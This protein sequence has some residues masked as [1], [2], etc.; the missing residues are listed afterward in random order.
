MVARFV[1]TGSQFVWKQNVTILSPQDDSGGSAFA[2]IASEGRHCIGKIF[3]RGSDAS[4][5]N[6]RLL[7]GNK[8]AAIVSLCS[9]D[10]GA[11]KPLPEVYLS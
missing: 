5:R 1:M 2:N 10:R 9:R 8:I 4:D 6:V 7:G 11:R 3:W